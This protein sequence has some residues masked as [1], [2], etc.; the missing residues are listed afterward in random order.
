MASIIKSMLKN[1]CIN[2]EF[3]KL[4]AADLLPILQNETNM[5]EN[6]TALHLIK[7]QIIEE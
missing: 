1:P 5:T 4:I 3:E 2:K 6:F 7:K